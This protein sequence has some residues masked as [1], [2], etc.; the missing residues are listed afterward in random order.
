MK[1]LITICARGGSKGI[2]GKN[3]K[4]IAGK[5]LIAYS[6]DCARKVGDALPGGADILL[7]TDS[8]EIRAC[9]ARWG[10][11]SDYRRPARLAEDHCAK[12]DAIAD[13][14]EWSEARQGCRYD[15]LLDLDCTSPLRTVDDVLEA[16][17]ILEGDPQALDIFSV[18]PASRNPYFNMVEQN[19]SGYYSLVKDGS[20]FTTRQSA[21]AV[22]DM[23]AS[24]YI[25]RR[26]FFEQGLRDPNTSRSLVYVMQ[27]RCFDLDE[28]VDFEFMRFLLEQHKLGFEL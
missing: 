25:Y 1:T 4:P 19:P 17:R 23:N 10:L 15:C 2:P 22:Y 18:S 8:D 28:P 11:E 7:S 9:A 12:L 5:P 21:P 13:A 14:L 26:A 3:I 24:F 27:H 16:F 6:I 20:R